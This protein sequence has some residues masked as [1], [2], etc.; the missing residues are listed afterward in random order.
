MDYFDLATAT[1][2]LAMIGFPLLLFLFSF[3]CLSKAFP[4]NT[5]QKKTPLEAGGAWP[6]VGHLRLLGGRQPP[7]ITLGGAIFSIKL[8]VH[9]ALVVSSSEIAKECLT[10]NSPLVQ[11]F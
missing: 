5:G 3:L 9:R 10:A 4:R 2:T 11:S 6:I 7:H 1:S 8:G